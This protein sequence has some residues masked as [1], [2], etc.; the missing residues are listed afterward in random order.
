M[1]NPGE[2]ASSPVYKF[3]FDQ[4]LEAVNRTAGAKGLLNSGNR[5]LDLTKFGQG[6]AGQQFFQMAPMLGRFAGADTSSPAAA[7]IS[8]ARGAT[9][10]IDAFNQQEME[11]AYADALRNAGGAPVGSPGGTPGSMPGSMGLPP[12]APPLST[13]PAQ[14]AYRRQTAGAPPAY[15]GYGGNEAYTLPPPQSYNPPLQDYTGMDAATGFGVENP[16]SQA[17]GLDEATGFG[18]ESP[19]SQA[20]GLDEATGF[21]E[22]IPMDGGSLSMI[23]GAL[24]EGYQQPMNTYG[25][26]KATFFGGVRG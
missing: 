1:R 26:W 16:F 10:G 22:D 12:L 8:Y 18:V 6:L 9:G 24:P 25:D 4:G 13:D 20:Q 11:R 14:E 2:F 19:V 21:G 17:Q 23:N 7:G 3:A 5:L 15:A